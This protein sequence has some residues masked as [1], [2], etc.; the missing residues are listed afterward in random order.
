M[1]DVY[2]ISI[3]IQLL[4]MFTQ[5]LF[6][7]IE[8]F[9]MVLHDV[10]LAYRHEIALSIYTLERIGSAFFVMQHALFVG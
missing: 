1:K 4:L 5:A 9:W 10:T 2:T 6:F 7:T 8:D 3:I